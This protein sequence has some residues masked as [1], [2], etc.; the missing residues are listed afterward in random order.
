MVLSQLLPSQRGPR[1]R[2]RNGSSGENARPRCPVQRPRPTSLRMHPPPAL[3]KSPRC[4]R[5]SGL[6]LYYLVL[7]GYRS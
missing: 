3:H 1:I 6:V 7:L 2:R 5:V 4:V